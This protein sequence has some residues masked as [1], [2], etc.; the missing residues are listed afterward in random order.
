MAR[1]NIQKT[2]FTAGEIS[3]RLLGRGDLRAYQNGAARL[4]NVFVHPTGGLS[5]RPGLRHIDTARG[6]GRLVPFEFNT[7]QVYLLVFTDSW[8]DVY[9]DGV[10]VTDFA[11]PWSETQIPLIS[12]VQSADTLLVTHI[13]VPPKKIVRQGETDW[14][15]ADWTFL[16]EQKP[17]EGST[18]AR[19]R[20]QQPHHKFAD[21]AVTLSASGTTGSVTLTTS[22]DHFVSAHV[23]TRYRMQNKE[24]N[25]TA[26]T[27]STQATATV[28]ETLSSVTATKDWEE[29]AFSAVRGWPASTCFHQD[30]LVIGGS[31]D[32][33][34]RLWLSKSADLFNFDLGEGL[35]DEAI[36]FAILSDQVNA[37]RAVFSGRHLQIFTSGAEWMATGDPLTPVNIQLNRQ[38]RIGSPVSRW[39]PPRDVDGATV[40]VAR[41]G[42]ELREFLFAD[43]E[44]AYQ[45]T[46]LA[47]LAGHIL[48]GPVDQDY[49][50][51][52]RLFHVVME[53]GNL[54]TVTMFRTEQVTAWTRQETDGAFQAVAIAGD[55]NF[56][57]TERSGAVFIERFDDTLNVDAGLTGSESQE[58]T[59]WSGLAHLEGRSVQI[60]ADGAP[61]AKKVVSS[62]QITLD[63]PAKTIELGL[64]FSHIVEP[65]PPAVQ[66]STGGNQG[67]RLRPVAITFRLENT[68][69]LRLDTGRGVVDIPFKGFG[70]GVLDSPPKPFSGDRTI[71]ALGW[72]RDGTVSLW[73]IEQDTPFSFTLL[74]V[75][76]EIGVNS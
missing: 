49:D 51:P 40:F 6:A 17:T 76:T 12:W 33:P 15:V 37:I 71:R 35:D 32:L 66:T 74:S 8:I 69:A 60:V 25:I 27:S 41:N 9:R 52:N 67:G 16:D 10:K 54:A 2:S 63:Q 65:L 44:Q 4:R 43:V 50:T 21:D 13:E 29:Q 36:E 38:T 11:A 45:A 55:E 20:V 19:D 28:K 47:T 56:V 62:G 64:P 48:S 61:V 5:R 18:P 75:A 7:E 68:R 39:L 58:K 3:P 53:D 34:N 57:L 72:K 73:R 1:L 30:R 70:A 24:L 31:R 14:Q 46:D 59:V 22:D 42:K 23:G 26:V